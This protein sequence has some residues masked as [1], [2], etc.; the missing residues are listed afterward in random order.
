MEENKILGSYKNGNYTV[1]IYEDG[2]K[3]FE[4][5]DDELLADFPDSIDTWITSKCDGVCPYCYAGCEPMGKHGIILR[6]EL[7]NSLHPYMEMAINVNDMSHPHLKM[8]LEEL[9][10]RKIIT[11]VTINQKHFVC[12]RDT[13]LSWQEDG[14]LHGLGVSI[15]DSR[16]KY[17][18]QLI[19]SFPHSVAHIIAGIATEQD[20]EN[21][22]ILPRVL[23]LGYKLTGSSKQYFE[24]NQTEYLENIAAIR[25]WLQNGAGNQLIAFDNAAIASLAIR[26]MVTD[27]VWAENFLGK[28]GTDTFFMDLV[29]ER[30]GKNSFTDKTYKLTDSVDEMFQVIR[31]ET[32]DDE[33]NDTNA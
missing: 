2:T 7:L 20:L 5:D 17:G 6:P 4:T 25:T 21:I 11:N 33:S 24:Q 22:S 26:D 13:L 19:A 9:K 16:D 15:T 27:E 12:N 1:T 29:N 32:T 18:L 28:E 14:L 31:K 30:F 8:F 23:I 3:K 10:A